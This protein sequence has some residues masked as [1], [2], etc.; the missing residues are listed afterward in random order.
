MSKNILKEWGSRRRIDF[1]TPDTFSKKIIV[2]ST[3]TNAGEGET[4]VTHIESLNYFTAKLPGSGSAWKKIQ[5]HNSAK[6]AF[7]F[8]E[9]YVNKLKFKDAKDIDKRGKHAV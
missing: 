3:T 8:H 9:D 2:V 5:M 7:K 6:D 4:A 1:L